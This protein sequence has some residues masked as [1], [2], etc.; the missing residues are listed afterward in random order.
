MIETIPLPTTDDPVDRT[1]WQGCTDGRLLVQNCNDCGHVQHPPRAMCP[2]CQSMDLG[3]KQASGRAT[4]WSYTIPHPPLLPA[5][6]EIG[7]YVVAVVEPDDFPGLRIV[8]ALS[9]P[10]GDSIGGIGPD[11]VRIGAPV[12]LTFVQLAEDVALP[13]WFPAGAGV[14]TEKEMQQ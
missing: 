12:N 1:F 14:P 7:P 4:I 10:K 5:F 8:G 11:A 13:C 9:D 6:A 2:A 3:W